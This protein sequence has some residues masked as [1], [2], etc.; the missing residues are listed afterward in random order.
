MALASS[1]VCGRP[2]LPAFA[3][4]LGHGA[5]IQNLRA[6]LNTKTEVEK[7]NSLFFMPFPPFPFSPFVVVI[8][9]V[10]VRGGA[11]VVFSL[12]CLSWR[13]VFQLSFF[14]YAQRII[15]A[16]KLQFR[17]ARHG[18]EMQGG[19]GGNTEIQGKCIGNSP[20]RLATGMDQPNSFYKQLQ[21]QKH[22]RARRHFV[23]VSC[24]S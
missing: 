21:W 11:A 19:N 10:V 9:V 6:K 2:S 7:I 8:V 23:L 18:G 1:P 22:C 4:A 5:G 24:C 14:Y 3:A 16:A 15:C 20:E 17:S 13:F 12:C